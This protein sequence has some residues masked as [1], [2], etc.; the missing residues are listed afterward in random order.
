K[1]KI[2]APESEFLLKGK[3]WYITSGNAMFTLNKYSM[4]IITAKMVIIH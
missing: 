3:N 1:A 4:T 2:A